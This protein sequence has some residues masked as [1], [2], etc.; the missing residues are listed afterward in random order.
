[1]RIGTPIRR[2]NSESVTEEGKGAQTRK[3]IDG[4]G[5]RGRGRGQLTG[6]G[7]WSRSESAR[8]CGRLPAQAAMGPAVVVAY[9]LAQD[10]PAWRSLKTM[11][12]SRQSRQ[13]VPTSRSQ[14]AF[15]SAALEGERRHCTPRPRSRTRKPASYLDRAEKL[16]A[17]IVL[18]GRSKRG[19]AEGY[20]AHQPLRPDDRGL[21]KRRRSWRLPPAG[22]R[23]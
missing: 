7:C 21:F 20:W 2:R 6:C 16:G 8:A 18:D 9:V 17:K 11:T 1:M 19:G 14:I 10:A 15:A 5:R 22:S 4:A 3:H 12:W 23:R 13:S